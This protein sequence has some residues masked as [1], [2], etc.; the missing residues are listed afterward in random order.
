MTIDLDYLNPVRIVD[1]CKIGSNIPA[2]AAGMPD[3][4]KTCL[5]IAYLE[6]FV[7]YCCLN[8]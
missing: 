5:D 1:F 8:R 6:C 7:I 3:K 4:Q 2:L